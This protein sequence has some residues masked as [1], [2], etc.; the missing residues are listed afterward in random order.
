MPNGSRERYLAACLEV[1]QTVAPGVAGTVVRAEILA[2][3]DLERSARGRP[4]K[5]GMDAS[6]QDKPGRSA[7]SSPSS[8]P[9]S[10]RLT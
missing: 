5:Y 3:P 10:G 6:A 8:R 1:V 2:P 9:E 7:S 4:A